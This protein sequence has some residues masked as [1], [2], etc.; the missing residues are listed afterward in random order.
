[1]NAAGNDP[2]L[3]PE[4]VRADVA[5]LLGCDPAEIDPDE[6]LLDRGVDSIRLMSLVEQWRQAGA[7]GLEFAD[8]AEQPVL[9]HWEKLVG[10]GA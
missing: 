7:T 8:L 2:V 1:M 5:D 6:D 3:A 10:G 9:R 4:Q